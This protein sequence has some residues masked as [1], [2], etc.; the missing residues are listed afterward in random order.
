M[1]QM[2][3]ALVVGFF[4]NGFAQTYS[5]EGRV[6]YAA[7]YNLGRWE[8][9]NSSVQG[10]VTWAKTGEAS[11]Q[12]CVD[13]KRFD[14]GNAIRDADTRGIFDSNRYPTSC[15]EVQQLQVQGENAVLV[16]SLEIKGVRA[17]VRFVGKLTEEKN[18]Y[19]FQGSL[20]TSFSGWKLA[21]PSLVFLTVDDAIE[22]R[23]EATAIP[24]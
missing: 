11:G 23:L 16:G 8:G 9:S 24:K 20:R 7:S 10:S 1:K 2:L 3:W 4:C 12:V 21:R 14:S 6:V 19:R 22:I 5:I 13:L 17:V 15:L 18:T